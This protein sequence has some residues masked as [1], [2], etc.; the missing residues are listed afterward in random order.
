MSVI[1]GD[2]NQYRLNIVKQAFH[3]LDKNQNGALDI[4]EVKSKFD[5]SR[6]PDAQTGTRTVDDCGFEFVDMFNTHHNVTHNFQQTREVSLDEFIDYHRYISAF[7]ESD[8]VFKTFM[9]GVWNM[10]LVETTAAIVGGAPVRPAGITPNIYGKN[11]REQWKYDFHRTFFGT[12]DQTPMKH[13][14]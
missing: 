7:I 13:N 4:D 5:P 6:H 8:K 9:S 3:H 2:L 14:I 12:L 10:D 1:V 11:S